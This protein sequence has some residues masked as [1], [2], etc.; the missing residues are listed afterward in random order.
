MATFWMS[1]TA[2][3]ASP[4][5]IGMTRNAS[6]GVL[7]VEAR[8]DFPDT[9]LVHGAGDG[10]DLVVH[11]VDLEA[12]VTAK[13]ILSPEFWKR[14]ELLHDVPERV[15]SSGTHRTW[16]ARRLLRDD[17]LDVPER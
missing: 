13:A 10:D 15:F 16:S 3:V 9:R 8:D 5:C 12:D 14:L 7:G 1:E 17:R 4:C 11:I 2:A 6:P